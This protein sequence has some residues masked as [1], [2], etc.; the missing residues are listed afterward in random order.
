VLSDVEI[1]APTA[2]NGNC[3]EEA[4]PVLFESEEA[5]RAY[6]GFTAFGLRRQS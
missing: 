1:A 4:V 3:S 6:A 2:R 5:G